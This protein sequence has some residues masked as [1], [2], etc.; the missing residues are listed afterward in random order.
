MSTEPSGRIYTRQ[1][2]HGRPVEMTLHNSGKM[3]RVRL[4]E[5]RD[6]P[7]DPIRDILIP[8]GNWDVRIAVEVVGGVAT[9]TIDRVGFGEG[10]K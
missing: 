5:F 6:D 2:A 9:V 1:V 4:A 3:A 10:K 8:P 7:D